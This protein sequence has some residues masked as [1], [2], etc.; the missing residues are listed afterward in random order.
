MKQ[1]PEAHEFN[2]IPKCVQPVQDHSLCSII[3]EFVVKL[4]TWSWSNIIFNIEISLGLASF[5]SCNSFTGKLPNTQQKP[6]GASKL[7]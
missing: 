1:Y 7:M 2:D 5:C 6:S 3:S 4:W